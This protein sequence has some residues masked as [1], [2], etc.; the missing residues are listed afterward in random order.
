MGADVNA[1][2]SGAYELAKSNNDSGMLSLLKKYGATPPT[3]NRPALEEKFEQDSD[4][5]QDLGIGLIYQIEKYCQKEKEKLGV[6]LEDVIPYSKNNVYLL[7]CVDN[8]KY[9]YVKY[10]LETGKADVH[11]SLSVSG[12]SKGIL[13]RYAIWNGDY[14]MIKLLSKYGG[15]I[16]ESLTSQE[17]NNLF[18]YPDN[19]SIFHAFRSKKI[20]LIKNILIKKENYKIN[21]AFTEESDPI[22]DLRI[23]TIYTD[24][25]VEDE[26][27]MYELLCQVIPILLNTYS[28]P[29]DILNDP[30]TAGHYIHDKYAYTISKY[31]RKYITTKNGTIFNY[32]K[33]RKFLRK[34]YPNLPTDKWG[35][36]KEYINEKFE[37]DTDSIHDLGIGV[38]AIYDNIKEG[39]V[40]ILK[41]DI[42]TLGKIFIK[43]A[44][45]EI[46]DVTT[47]PLDHYDKNIVYSLYLNKSHFKNKK[48]S[49]HNEWGWSY[50][51]FKDYFLPINIKESM[52]EK[53][54]EDDDPVHSMGIGIDRLIKDWFNEIHIEQPKNASEM[55]YF[56]AAG[57][58]LDF[59]KYLVEEKKADVKYKNSNALQL[60]AA[61]G[62]I[63]VVK[64]LLEKGSDPT[65]NYSFGL[66]WAARQGY[67]DIAKILLEAG[68]DPNAVGNYALKMAINYGHK[69]IVKLLSQFQSKSKINNIVKESLNEKFEEDSDPIE[70]LRIG[71][72]W[73]RISPGDIILNNRKMSLYDKF[74]HFYTI[75]YA[76]VIYKK[77]KEDI[78][79]LHVSAFND[80]GAAKF[81]SQKYMKDKDFISRY[82]FSTWEETHDI[83]VWEKDFYIFKYPNFEEEN[84]PISIQENFSEESDPIR[85]LQIGAQEINF[86]KKYHEICGPYNELGVIEHLKHW[87]IFYKGLYGK[88]IE[89]DFY[90]G[91]YF[92]K[93]IHKSFIINSIISYMMLGTGDIFLVD[94]HD[95]LYK[96]IKESTY[97]IS[98]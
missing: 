63:D 92:D 54:E 25:L 19:E 96:I 14:K 45:V 22:R 9:E 73:K 43:G 26:K 44:Y 70:D 67:Y 1:Y 37:E 17:L 7:I 28:I 5:L 88:R 87:V 10:L 8:K 33:F 74:N 78:L 16:S 52:N 62:H 50:D 76:V 72:R 2:D 81:V 34:K 49:D 29:D 85:D 57:D 93:K 89:G 69:N 6:L 83:N 12:L 84:L 98:K 90:T 47:R 75:S 66:R 13:M 23:G 82:K 20:N 48:P 60:A 32:D 36:R 27:E 65:A 24:I 86:Q 55:L 35:G 39:D 61:N 56:C 38:K 97:I 11:I 59:V 58:K 30:S 46:H 80:F 94:L 71:N 21:E 40:F 41:K 42:P 79:T 18:K 91:K 77:L 68:A 15:L 64:Y 51:F 53:F 4:P 95:N 31:A 3:G